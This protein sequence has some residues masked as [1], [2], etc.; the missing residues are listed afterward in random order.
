MQGT[1]TSKIIMYAILIL[2]SICALLPFYL[3]AIMSSYDSNSL[4]TGLHL[5]P[6]SNFG[7]NITDVF[8]NAH[9]ERYYLNS[10]YIAILAV[11][12]TVL[13]SAMC[14]YA[15]AKYRF[16]LKKAAYNLVLLTMMLPPQLGLVA[17]VWEMKTIGWTETHWPLIVPAAVNAFAV[18]WMRQYVLQ[19]V[20]D[21]IIESARIDGC[22]E[23]RIFFSIVVP[24]IKP[25]LGSQALLS[26]MASWNSYLLPLVL[27][28]KQNKYT[29]TLGLATLDTLYRM[30]YGAR[31][32]AL[33]LGTIPM[34][35]M[36]LIFSKSLIKGLT[37]GSVKG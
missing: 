2:A 9:F 8:L 4:F 27:I 18:Y 5:L 34:F 3:M 30:N 35:L 6:G 17:F 11:A 32:T 20:P 13:I 25:A 1:K 26:F 15:L 16:G 19:G 21:E 7:I 22:S 36:F 10:L 24:F 12:L 23:Y 29:V 14:G 31:I 28:N 33:L 37:A